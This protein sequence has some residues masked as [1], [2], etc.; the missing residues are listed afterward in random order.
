MGP[1]VM[2]K[3]LEVRMLLLQHAGSFWKH[4]DG[5][6]KWSPRWQSESKPTDSEVRFWSSEMPG[7]TVESK[8]Q[9]L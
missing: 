1:A 2:L 8:K 3:A 5:S 9:L 4:R 7:E 6:D